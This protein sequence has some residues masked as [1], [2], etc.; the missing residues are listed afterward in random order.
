[1][2]PLTNHKWT[3][4]LLVEEVKASVRSTPQGNTS[5]SYVPT[6]PGLV[7]GLSFELFE[8]N[9]NIDYLLLSHVI[10]CQL[11]ISLWELCKNPIVVER[12]NFT[13]LA[14]DMLLFWSFLVLKQLD[15]YKVLT[16][17]CAKKY[18]DK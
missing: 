14:G 10:E 4:V 15:L 8:Q 9:M 13:M 1:M 6:F 12:E 17:K 2:R 18:E 5:S 16:V 7:L 3:P 11:G